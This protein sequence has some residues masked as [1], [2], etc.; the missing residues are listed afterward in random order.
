MPVTVLMETSILTFAELTA[1][2][3]K[4]N[5]RSL[6]LQVVWSDVLAYMICVV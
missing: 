4:A 5:K 1:A 6:A 2:P 3:L